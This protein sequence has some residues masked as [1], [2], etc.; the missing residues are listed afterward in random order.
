MGSFSLNYYTNSYYT[1]NGIISTLYQVKIIKTLKY[2]EIN[3]FEEV[4]ANFN[5]G[6][7]ALYIEHLIF[8]IVVSFIEH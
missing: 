3:V 5:N 8:P 4:L 7:K 6:T 2:M 1:E